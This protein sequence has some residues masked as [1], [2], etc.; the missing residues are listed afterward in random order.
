MD[1]VDVDS[2]DEESDDDYAPY[3]QMQVSGLILDV[4]MVERSQ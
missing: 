2:S 4:Q 1:D 3:G